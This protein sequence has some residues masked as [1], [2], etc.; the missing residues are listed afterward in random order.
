MKEYNSLNNNKKYKILLSVWETSAVRLWQRKCSAH[1][2]TGAGARTSSSPIPPASSIFTKANCPTRAC[3]RTPPAGATVSLTTPARSGQTTSG[4]LTSS[5]EWTSRTSKAC[6]AWP[7]A[8]TMRPKLSAWQ[9]TSSIQ[10]HH[11]FPTPITAPTKT[12]NSSLTCSK[13]PALS[14]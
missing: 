3:V 12:L 5:S 10:A 14:F 7:K 6:N 9:T 11:T 2:P 8:Q 4:S 13:K 1:W